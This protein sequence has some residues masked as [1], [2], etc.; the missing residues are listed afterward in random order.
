MVLPSLHH[1]RTETS[2]QKSDVTGETKTES[3]SLV[4]FL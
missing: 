4:S 3:T 2:L 1:H